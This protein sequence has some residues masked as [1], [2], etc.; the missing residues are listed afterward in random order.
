MIDRKKN[1]EFGIL[2][3]LALMVIAIWFKMELTV[4]VIIILLVTLLFPKIYTP[5]TW[6]WFKLGEWLGRIV[7][8]C[9]L[10][11]LFFLIITPVSCVRRWMNNDPL[12]LKQ[13]G[14]GSD[15]VFVNQEKIYNAQD[16]EKQY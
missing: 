13:F 1:I 9:I 12:Q 4:P 7:T 16:L 3:A 6:C 10:F 14:K 15:S 5:F 8:C 2:L 11:L